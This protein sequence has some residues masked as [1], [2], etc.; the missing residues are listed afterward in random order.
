MPWIYAAWSSKGTAEIISIEKNILMSGRQFFEE[1]K[2]DILICFNSGVYKL[3]VLIALFLVGGVMAGCAANKSMSEEEK[4]LS[5]HRW[6]E[7]SDKSSEVL[8]Q[9][10]QEENSVF[11]VYFEAENEEK[12]KNY[13]QKVGGRLI[14]FQMEIATIEV[15]GSQDEFFDRISKIKGIPEMYPVRTSSITVE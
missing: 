7:T 10:L 8:P 3:V 6:Q 14:R 2:V 11:Q 12:A 1:R 4:S 9:K 15:E 13:A 5:E